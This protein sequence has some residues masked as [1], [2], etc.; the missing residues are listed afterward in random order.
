[1]YS[2]IY[3]AYR[4]YLEDDTIAIS[5][6]R[7]ENSGIPQVEMCVCVCVCVCV[8][9]YTYIHNI[10]VCTSLYICIATDR[11]TDRQTDRDTHTHTQ[12]HTTHTHTQ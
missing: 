7:E 5:E 8:Y 12:T 10:Y 6:P 3:T 1:M 11:Q 2:D 4:Y 9:I